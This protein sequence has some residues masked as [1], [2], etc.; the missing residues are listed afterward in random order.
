ML[1]ALH[2][3]LLRHRKI[4]KIKKIKMIVRYFSN[5]PGV[6]FLRMRWS[7]DT[8]ARSRMNLI[9]PSYCRGDKFAGLLEH[10]A[11]GVR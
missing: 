7:T 4:E 2:L 6:K 9:W 3:F 1:V 5:P 8:G 10:V 11:G